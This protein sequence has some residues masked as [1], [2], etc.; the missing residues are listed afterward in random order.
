MR[1]PRPWMVQPLE[2]WVK[3][4]RARAVAL[5]EA[6]RHGWDANA[7]AAALLGSTQPTFGMA[8]S[9][10]LGWPSGAGPWRRAGGC[11]RR[12]GAPGGEPGCFQTAVRSDRDRWVW[13]EGVAV[14]AGRG[15]PAT[16]RWGSG[17]KRGPG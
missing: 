17:R 13:R 11:C 10:R 5:R 3:A 6:V 14:V 1:R 16:G 15:G 12:A 8:W 9:V 2:P 4:R 7:V